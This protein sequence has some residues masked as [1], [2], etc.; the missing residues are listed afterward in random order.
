MEPER[1]DEVT[2]MEDIV[3]HVFVL[4]IVAWTVII[5]V[6]LCVVAYLLLR[7]RESQLRPSMA[8]PEQH[9]GPPHVVAEVRQAPFE[10]GRPVPELKERQRVLLHS[11]G[12]VDRPHGVIRIPVDRAIDLLLQQT[13]AARPVA[14]AVQP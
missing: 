8:F 6:S 3:P 12:W 11:Y 9:L 2:F 13:K 1:H 4:R 7:L 10:V 5:A 14:P